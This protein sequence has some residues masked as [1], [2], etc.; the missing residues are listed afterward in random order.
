MTARYYYSNEDD[1][2]MSLEEVRECYEIS[3]RDGDGFLTD[4]FDRYL[5]GCMSRNNGDLT[6]LDTYAARL[7]R[8]LSRTDDSDYAAFLAAQLDECKKLMEV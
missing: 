3:R 8:D 1:R 2:I 6:P 5:E 4:S 7:S